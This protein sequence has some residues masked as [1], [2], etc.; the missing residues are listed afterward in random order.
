MTTRRVRKT[1]LMRDVEERFQRPLERLLP[2]LVNQYGLSQAA[3]E[4]GVSTS[5][6]SYWMLKL[7]VSY[8]RVA[9]NAQETIEVKRP[10]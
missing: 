10:G 7:G 4:I 2:E 1:K 8:R 9:L 5:T 6:V 3:T